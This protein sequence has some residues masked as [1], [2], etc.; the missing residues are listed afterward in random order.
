[1]IATMMVVIVFLLA[2]ESQAHGVVYSIINEKATIISISY[3]T[4][5]PM[6]Y[7]K[8]KLFSP[9]N[10]DIEYQNGRTDKNGR[11]AFIPT[12]P[13]EWTL[14]VDDDM[15]HGVHETFIVKEAMTVE[16]QS[17]RSPRWMGIVSGLC[18][19][20]GLTGMAMGLKIKGEK[21]RETCM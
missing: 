12:E 1:M 19:I 10:P 6:S 9:S 3:D 20:F 17:H 11:F 14:S 8:V 21:T 15:A 2:R 5:E 18:V 7:A 13:G 4:D 16:T